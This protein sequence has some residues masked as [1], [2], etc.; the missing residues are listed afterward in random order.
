MD[1]SVEKWVDTHVHIGG[2]SE[3]GPSDI[4]AGLVEVFEKEEVELRFIAS[5]VSDWLRMVAEN[6]DG[7]LEAHRLL[8]QVVESLPDRVYGSCM[9]NP[10]FL[11][12]SLTSMDQC[13][14]EWGFV[15]LGELVTYLM[16]YRMNTKSMEK[17]VRKAVE[18]GVPIHVHIST[19]NAKPQGNFSSGEEELEDMLDLVERVPEGKYIVAHG[20]GA[21]LIHPPVVDTYLD[22]IDRRY[23]QWPENLWIEIMHFHA[24]GVSSALRYIPASKIMAGM[25]WSTGALPPYP[26]YGTIF[27]PAEKENPYPPSVESLVNLLAEAG[28]DGKMIK[29]IA[30]QNAF[31]LYGLEDSE[32]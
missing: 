15:Q 1:I 21:P 30:Y 17:L 25:D 19:S 20:I 24:A 16:N 12:A 32:H 10:H 18:Y 14:G 29:Q 22:I 9:V 28:A 26:L 11:D 23:G 4:I 31:E 5:P 27:G 7:I 13:F 6:G 2:T 3:C 8:H